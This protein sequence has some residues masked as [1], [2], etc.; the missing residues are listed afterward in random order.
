M[1]EKFK[2]PELLNFLCEEEGTDDKDLGGMT[3]S[4]DNG[5]GVDW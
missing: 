2:K 3:P 4:Q 5:P 1:M